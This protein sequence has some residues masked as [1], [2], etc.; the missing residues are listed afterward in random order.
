[1]KWLGKIRQQLPLICLISR[2]PFSK[3]IN[4]RITLSYK[5]MTFHT[6]AIN[7][8]AHMNEVQ[9]VH[10]DFVMNKVSTVCKL[11]IPYTN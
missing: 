5:S 7:I 8:L 6:N 9:N 1:M 11:M 4:Y 10:R 3:I 2:L